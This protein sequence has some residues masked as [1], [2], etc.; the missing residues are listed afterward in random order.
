[1][2]GIGQA[3]P[4]LQDAWLRLQDRW[5][6]AADRWHDAIRQR[7]ERDFVQEYERTLPAVFKEMDRLADVIAQ[8]RREVQ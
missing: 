6:S 1:M 3:R 7:F 5:Q 4:Q 8:A 2:N